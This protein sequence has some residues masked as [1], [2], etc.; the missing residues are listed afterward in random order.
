MV[1]SFVMDFR[2]FSSIGSRLTVNLSLLPPDGGSQHESDCGSPNY[3]AG[4]MPPDDL[5]QGTE[6][7]SYIMGT[8]V[9]R[10][11]IQSGRCAFSQIVDCFGTLVSGGPNG[12]SSASERV[13]RLIPNFVQLLSRGPAHIRDLLDCV[14]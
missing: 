1:I 8:H 10:R 9:F 6:H 11:R 5:S 3:K 14:R 13:C 4:R 12:G 2:L 7:P